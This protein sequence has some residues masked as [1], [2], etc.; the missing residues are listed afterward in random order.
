MND[1][2]KESDLTEDKK[3]KARRASKVLSMFAWQVIRTEN[4]RKKEDDDDEVEE[5]DED[6]ENEDER[7]GRGGV[8]LKRC[9]SSTQAVKFS[10]GQC[11][12]PILVWT[13]FWL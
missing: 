9:S 5:E 11:A 10:L 13:S 1:H 8:K 12:S 2:K 3:K 4:K 6:E 7:I